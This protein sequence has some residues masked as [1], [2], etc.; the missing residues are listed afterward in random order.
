MRKIKCIDAILATTETLDENE[1][2]YISDI[3]RSIWKYSK[4]KQ[5]KE[6]YSIQAYTN[7]L[8]KEVEVEAA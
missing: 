6:L 8:I 3:L 1:A 5:L 2:S 4:H 7:E